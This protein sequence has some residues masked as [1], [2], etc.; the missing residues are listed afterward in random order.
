MLVVVAMYPFETTV[1]PGWR[2]RVVDENGKPY[3]GKQVR[4][5]WKHYTL[6]REPG[7]NMEDQFT[8]GDG[9][10]T[11]PER[12]IRANLFSRVMLTTYSALMTFAHGS[13]GIH[14]DVAASGP[15]GYKSVAY[16]PGK[17]LPEQIV[18]PSKE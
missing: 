9:Q 3:V 13:Y 11:F 16:V 7:T 5:A 4:Q 10:V 12:I 8:D 18:L 2:L 15:Q 6:D 1:V 17:P 14:A